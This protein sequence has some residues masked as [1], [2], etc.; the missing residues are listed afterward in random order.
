MLILAPTREL[1]MQIYD[2]FAKFARE[3]F[4]FRLALAYGGTSRQNQK[5]IIQQGCDVLIATPGRLI[6]FLESCSIALDKVEFLVIDEAD[7][8]LDMGFE[9]QIKKINNYINKSRLF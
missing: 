8:M 1:V 5:I 6:D 2:E 4:Y 7:R 3:Q 9:P